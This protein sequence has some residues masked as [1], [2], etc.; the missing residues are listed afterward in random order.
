MLPEIIG[1]A[2][3]PLDLRFSLP[4]GEEATTAQ[5]LLVSNNPYQLAHLRG[6]GT[7]E[8]IDGGHLGIVSVLVRGAADVEALAALEATGRVQ[9]FRGWQEWTADELEVRSDAPVEVGVDGEALVLDPPLRFAIHP[10]ALTVRLPRSA[11]GRSPGARAF[12]VTSGSTVSA[13]WHTAT[14]R[15]VA[16]R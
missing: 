2:A 4:S 9:R 16:G 10:G 5:L 11:V 8:R 12:R 14:G 3:T 6:G 1:P 7:R 15:P 13:L